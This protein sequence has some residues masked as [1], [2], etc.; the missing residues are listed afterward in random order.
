MRI[1]S[2]NIHGCIGRDGREDPDRILDVIRSTDADIVG[3][4]EVHH[5]DALDRDFLRKLEHLPYRT[6]IYGKTLRKT[7]ADYG[8]LLLLR[9][10]PQQIQRIEL[11]KQ[12]GEARGAIIADLQHHGRKVRIIT[13]HLDIRSSERKRQMAAVL[14]QLPTPDAEQNCI[15]VGDLNE[16]LPQRPYFRKFQAQFDTISRLKTFPVRPA[17]FALDRIALKGKIRTCHFKTI[18]SETA[19]LASDHRPLLSDVD[20]D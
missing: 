8:N 13:T 14:Q 4:Q 7:T 15:L 3:L 17:L 5:D 12:Q 11:P 16:W 2:Y 18:D 10:P 19:K 1:V 20:W 9:E 6:V